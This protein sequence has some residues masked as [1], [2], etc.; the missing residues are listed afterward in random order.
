VRGY[1]KRGEGGDVGRTNN[2]CLATELVG[3][4]LEE[5]T[6]D[7]GEYSM[8]TT[9]VDPIGDTTK[10]GDI[11][12]SKIDNGDDGRSG[13]ATLNNDC[14]CGGIKN[15]FTGDDGFWGEN[16]D[17]VSGSQYDSAGTGGNSESRGVQDDVVSGSGKVARR[18][19]GG[20]GARQD[21]GSIVREAEAGRRRMLKTTTIQFGNF[22]SWHS[23]T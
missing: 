7:T 10:P 13:D 11:A 5:K 19:V 12:I 17:G 23:Q 14:S 1:K 9:H 18:G 3:V 22:Q 16:G 8:S 21:T 4:T 20:R 15:G 2:V 6:G